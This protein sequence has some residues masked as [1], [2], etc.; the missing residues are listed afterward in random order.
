MIKAINVAFILLTILML[1][2]S[3]SFAQVEQ[4]KDLFQHSKVLSRHYYGFSLYD[5]DSNR[6]LYAH[7][8]NQYFTPASNTK[9]YTLYASL[10]NISDSVPGLQYIERGDSL[11]F[12]GTGDPTFLHPQL[13]NGRVYNFLKYS[14][15]ELFYLEQSNPDG[16]FRPGWA[17]EDYN[18]SYQRDI[19]PF[20]IYA[21]L[22]HFKVQQGQIIAT[23]S[24]FS[25]SIKPLQKR[26][27]NFHIQRHLGQN[28]FELR[29]NQI[30]RNSFRTVKP[31]IWTDSLF[32]NLLSDTL[33]RSVQLVQDIDIR[34]DEEV[35]T[36]YSTNRDLV[37]REMM[38]P[39]D[40]FLAEQLTMVAS[41]QQY[42]AFL[43]DSLRK[44]MA[45]SDFTN[46]VDTAMLW[47]GSG[48]SVYNKITPENVIYLLLTLRSMLDDEYRLKM[49]FPAGGVDGTLKN[50]YRVGERGPF[51]WAKTGT[52]RS[53][54]CQ[55]GY[56]Q[57][58]SGRNLAFSFLNN[59]F[60]TSATPVRQ[61]VVRLV[62]Y[63]YENF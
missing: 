28:V 29:G 23:P 18:F 9:I 52:L 34:A 12:W 38:L 17:I 51:V 57:T 33:Q 50:A 5:L 4:L 27:A 1:S 46:F 32:V 3:R 62:T 24:F 22:V 35:K 47:D 60:R 16:T 40:N 7:Q 2:F 15:K 20:P 55:S 56:I 44:E 11:I 30:P 25:A 21:N 37:L 63:I 59:N 49:F 31:F 42:G 19:T 10:K 48:L 14:E 45:G 13:D 41:Y 53:V 54:Y 43:T 58:R 6:T 39:S 36:Y 8:A 61:E 26:K